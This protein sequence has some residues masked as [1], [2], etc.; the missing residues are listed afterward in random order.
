VIIFQQVF[1]SFRLINEALKGL[2]V[3]PELQ[4][5]MGHVMTQ[6]V[7]TIKLH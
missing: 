1:T 5:I 6:D 4:I 7:L 3:I 2:E